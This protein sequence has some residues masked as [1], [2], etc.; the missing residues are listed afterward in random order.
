MCPR[1]YSKEY[2][3]LTS[4]LSWII[5]HTLCLEH[6][7]A[8]KIAT[9]LTSPMSNVQGALMSFITIPILQITRTALASTS[10][11]CPQCWRDWSASLSCYWPLPPAGFGTLIPWLHSWSPGNLPMMPILSQRMQGCLELPSLLRLH[12]TKR[13]MMGNHVLSGVSMLTT[14]M[15]SWL[16]AAMFG[17]CPREHHILARKG[18]WGSEHLWRK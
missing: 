3:L 8:S 4:D 7:A 5:Q 1:H 9:W 12:C 10:V 14:L 6:I 2:N 16:T 17:N 15:I 18:C 11:G 13:L